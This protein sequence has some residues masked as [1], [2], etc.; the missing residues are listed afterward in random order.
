MTLPLPSSLDDDSTGRIW[1]RGGR[2]LEGDAEEA[3][4]A[5]ALEEAETLPGR[6]EKLPGALCWGRDGC[7]S[8]GGEVGAGGSEENKNDK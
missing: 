5:A 8:V 3:A 4:A 6:G 2:T 7:I 1:G